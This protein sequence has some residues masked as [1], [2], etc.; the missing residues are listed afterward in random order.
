MSTYTTT[1]KLSEAR[2]AMVMTMN[3]AMYANACQASICFHRS[4]QW[5]ENSGSGMGMS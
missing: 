5:A 3:T 4:V 2:A 1:M